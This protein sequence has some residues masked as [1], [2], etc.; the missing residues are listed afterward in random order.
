MGNK[1]K[2]V[3]DDPV[4]VE[5]LA[6]LH[7]GKRPRVEEESTLQRRHW[8]YIYFQYQQEWG[9]IYNLEK[10]R[11]LIKGII[12]RKLSVM[13]QVEM[14]DLKDTICKLIFLKNSMFLYLS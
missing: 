4:E 7:E 9:V 12:E 10:E 5:I 3:L 11:L 6:E 8:T 14:L 2:R 13:N 1:W